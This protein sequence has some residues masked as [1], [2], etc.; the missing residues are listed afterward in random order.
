MLNFLPPQQVVT[1]A[2]E[3]GEVVMFFC[4]LGKDRTGLIAL[5]ILSCCGSSDDEI[6]SDY[7]RYALH[8][9]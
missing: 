4:K 8:R 9:V 7:A 5:L 1:E 2:A 3:A 6:I